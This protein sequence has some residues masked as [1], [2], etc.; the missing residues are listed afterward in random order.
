MSAG[1]AVTA[2]DTARQVADAVL[3]EGYVLFPYR[4][5]AT[6]NRY[7]WQWGVLIPRSQAELGA[8][9]PTNAR[10]EVPLRIDRVDAA[11][12]VTARFLHL[13]RR[14]VRDTGDELVDRLEVD[15]Q[16]HLSWDEGLEQEVTT[17]P[18]SVAT[19]LRHPH[20]TAFCCEPGWTDEPLG[21]AGR[22]E[23]ATERIDGELRVS[24]V[25]VSDGVVRFV[26]TVH[27]LTD[28]SRPGAHR[29]E[30]LRRSLVSTHLILSVDGGVFASVIDPPGW[31]GRAADECH[32]RTVHPVLVGDEGA[33]TVVLAT[34]IILEDRP[35]I[36]PES[37]G[38]TYDALE[39]DELLALCV[40]GLSDDEK[41][42]ARATDPLAAELIERNES[43]PAAA[44]E[45][46]H[47]RVHDRV[48]DRVWDV[49]SALTELLGVGEAALDTVDID[50][51]TVSLGDLVRLRPRRRADAHDLFAEGR[52]AT[53]EKIVATVEGETMLAVT[54]VDDPAAEYHR[55]YGRFQYF[56]LDE[57]EPQAEGDP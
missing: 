26:A 5:S 56:H 51:S 34:P 14:Q 37:T 7:R 33:D 1:P 27:N 4:A 12:T 48:D 35:T 36:A 6:K 31:T 44:L 32:S 30:V 15:G 41:R 16:L 18:R 20:T 8:T 10:C 25:A 23:R 24:A 3:Y 29:D 11:V 55:W 42:E 38:P 40:R 53:V 21:T 22:I 54:L 57:V 46:L 43:L 19:L 50:G 13:R 47:G 39:I 9:E 45:R 52:I 2:L 49:D 17:G 28:W